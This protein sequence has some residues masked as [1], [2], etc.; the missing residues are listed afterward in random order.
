MTM[1]N[2]S[3][4]LINA[5]II[6]ED[7]LSVFNDDID[8]R[9]L[10]HGQ[11]EDLCFLTLCQEYLGLKRV[12]GSGGDR[13]VDAYIGRFSAPEIIFQF[14]HFKNSFGKPQKTE[15]ARSFAA[16]SN[17][18]NFSRW[19]LVCSS[20]PTPAMQAWLDEFEAEHDGVKIEYIF[21]SEMRAKVINCPKVRKQYF[22]NIQDSLESLHGERAHNPLVA[23]ARNIK[24]YNDIL[25]DDR[26]TA[27]VTIDGD[28]ETIVYSFKPWVKKPIPAIKLYPK[29][30]Q[31]AQAV[32]GLIKE[33]RPFVLSTDDLDFTSLIDPLVCDREIA[34]IS[35]FCQVSPNPTSLSLYAGDNPTQSCSLCVELKTVREGSDVLVRSNIDQ[36]SAP[37]VFE[38]EFSKIDLLRNC[39]VSVTPCFIGKTVRQASRGARFLRCLSETKLI[40]IAEANSDFEDATFASLDDIENDAAWR[41]SGDLFD[42]LDVI[43]RFFGINP[44]V[45]DAIEDPD[46]VSSMLEFGSKLL[47]NGE[48]IDGAI[49]FGVD[50]DNPDFLNRAMANE[51]ICLV[52]DQVW[53][54]DVFGVRCEANMRIAAKGVLE[55]A[56][57]ERKNRFRVKGSYC[58]YLQAVSA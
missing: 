15:I 3:T 41:L 53:H 2:E 55:L 48:K 56:D 35:A 10:S 13:G 52:V 45:T 9:A 29:T 28:T 19:I 44:I 6:E 23:A 18:F 11:W 43:C 34:E 22:P 17:A 54:G 58:V 51:Q 30:A 46:F 14:K 49:S 16:A 1:E 4:M 25:L 7:E 33:G 40:G 47:R 12:D 31:G 8:F 32:G 37:V 36:N 26:F 21:G 24:L 38:M 39:K 57:S 42:A 20:D 27:T 50:K 5:I